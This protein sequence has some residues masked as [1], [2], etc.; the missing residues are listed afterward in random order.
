MTGV[1]GARCPQASQSSCTTAAAR[2]P[3]RKRKCPR[4]H[5]WFPRWHLSVYWCRVVDGCSEGSWPALPRLVG[6][7]LRIA[8]SGKVSPESRRPPS[9]KEMSGGGC[10]LQPPCLFPPSP[11]RSNETSEMLALPGCSKA[12]SRPWCRYL[13]FPPLVRVPTVRGGGGWGGRRERPP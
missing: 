10:F 9:A 1:T 3:F 12:P 8:S 6:L 2:A 5:R 11:S 7:G 4:G 13:V